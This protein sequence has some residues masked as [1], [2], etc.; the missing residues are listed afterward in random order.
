[1]NNETYYFNWSQP[2]SSKY[3]GNFNVDTLGRDKYAAFLTNVLVHEAKNDGYVLN[4]N[5]PWGSGKTYFLKRWLY[6]LEGKHPTV[7]IDAWKQDYSDDPLLTVLSSIIEQ[8]KEQLPNSNQRVDKITK[9]AS[10]FFKAVAPTLTKG[11]VKKFSGIDLDEVS[12]NVD[13]FNVITGEAA[14]NIT[15]ALINDHNE[16]LESVEFLRSELTEWIDALKA[17]T[18]GLKLPAFIFIDELDRCRPSYAVEMLEVVKHFFNVPNIVFVIATDTEQLQHAVKAVYGVGFDAS[19]YLGRFFKRRFTLNDISRSAFIEAYLSE[20]TSLP[21]VTKSCWPALYAVSDLSAALAN[22]S[23]AFSLSLRETE[24]LCDKV[25]SILLNTNK[26][27]NVYF[28]IILFVL[29]DRYNSIFEKWFTFKFIPSS[30]ELLGHFANEPLWTYS[31]GFAY[32]VSSSHIP[33]S[34]Y[35]PAS[36]IHRADVSLLEILKLAKKYSRPYNANGK[37]ND[38]RAEL[39]RWDTSSSVSSD[40]MKKM[41]QEALL[42]D[43]TATENDYKNWV[44]LATSFD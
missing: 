28:L 8:F 27:F 23:D 1:M 10:R 7:Y 25:H 19:T 20:I 34:D 15:K 36:V 16:K 3:G 33:Y 4:L 31:V 14:S 44:E 32:S 17:L 5:A 41:M 38:L 18:D 2:I 6:E 42:M 37:F 35:F 40:R 22:I 13:D 26:S 21:E 43:I 9:Q 30:N 11:I 39:D 29:K 12:G 24:Q